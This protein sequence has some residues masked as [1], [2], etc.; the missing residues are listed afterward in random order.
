MS[1]R[2]V[3][4]WD[5]AKHTEQALA[6][7]TAAID[8]MRCC[9]PLPRVVLW[10]GAAALRLQAD[11][12]HASEGALSK[13]R[14]EILRP[15]GRVVGSGATP[16]EDEW[17][18]ADLRSE[19]LASPG[20]CELPGAAL[21]LSYEPAPKPAPDASAEPRWE[22]GGSMTRSGWT[23]RAEFWVWAEKPKDVPS[24]RVVVGQAG[25]ASSSAHGN[26]RIMLNHPSRSQSDWDIGGSMSRAGWS[27]KMEFWVP[28]NDVE[29]STPVQV[30]E[31]QNPHRALLHIGDRAPYTTHEPPMR[32]N[33]FFL[34]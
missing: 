3:Q 32:I 2:E 25:G 5:P 23:H 21:R 19:E 18:V 6:A 29:G 8:R 31:L 16:R 9:G 14:A 34:I 20:G 24:M 15:G 1:S 22:E 12:C 13:L 17:E 28:T 10:P 7:R 30:D 11:A 26:H 4:R 27:H 33:T